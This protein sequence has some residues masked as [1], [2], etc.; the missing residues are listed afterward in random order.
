MLLPPVLMAAKRAGH[1]VFIDG[2]YNVNIIGIRNANPLANRFDD[3][4]TVTYK[5]AAGNW[6]SYGYQCTLDPGLYWLENPGR[7]EGTAIVADG[8]H[9]GV[10]KIGT[11]KGAYKCL[12]QKRPIPVWRDNNKDEILDWPANDPGTPGYYGIQIHRASSGGPVNDVSKWSAG[13]AVVQHPDHF[14]DLMSIAH[15]AT[16]QWGNSLSFTI[17]REDQL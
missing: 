13:C 9:R 3:L 10:F 17:L 5:E 4:L 11:H 12:V 15:K 7:V 1:T 6:I 2:A 8:Q 14:G 16:A